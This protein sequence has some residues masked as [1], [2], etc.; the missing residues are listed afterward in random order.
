LRSLVKLCLFCLFVLGFNDSLTLFQSYCDGLWLSTTE[1][2]NELHISTSLWR[3][4]KLKCCLNLYTRKLTLN[5]LRNDK[6]LLKQI[7]C[8]SLITAFISN[9]YNETWIKQNDL[10]GPKHFVICELHCIQVCTI[11]QQQ[12]TAYRDSWFCNRV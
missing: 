7:K 11:K 12:G 5:E 4:G 3:V 10:H 8:Y 2:K 1:T 6:I 9:G